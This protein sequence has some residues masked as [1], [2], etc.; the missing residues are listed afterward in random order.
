[1]TVDRRDSETA[2]AA[3]A[4]RKQGYDAPTLRRGPR[5]TQVAASASGGG[6]TPAP[7]WVARAAFGADDIRWMVF[8]EWLLADAPAWFRA[9]YLRHGERA[10][11]WLAGKPRARAVVRRAMGVAIRRVLHRA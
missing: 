3:T 8:R 9:L 10:G 1:M 7:C 5:L 6:M 4:A 2:R 11:A